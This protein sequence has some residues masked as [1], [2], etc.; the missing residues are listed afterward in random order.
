M[1]KKCFVYPAESPL[2]DAERGDTSG[3][4]YVY[5]TIGLNR[6]GNAD[7]NDYLDYLQALGL[8]SCKEEERLMAQFKA[9]EEPRLWARCQYFRLL[10][11]LS[12]L[13]QIW[14]E[15]RVQEEKK[16]I[17]SKGAVNGAVVAWSCGE[18]SPYTENVEGA[19]FEIGC[20][21]KIVTL[22]DETLLESVVGQE[23]VIV[24]YDYR[25]G[26][27]Q[28]FPTDPMIGV[29]VTGGS[30]IEFWREELEVVD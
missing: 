27:G 23:G 2:G 16:L 5:S 11:Y 19:P 15:Q 30:V 8:D 17:L 10:G 7:Y 9:Q 3:L 22:V 4:R 20:R 25:S 21:V 18:P 13:R 26:C 29:R 6:Q 24:H 28:K 1:T 14:P 12:A